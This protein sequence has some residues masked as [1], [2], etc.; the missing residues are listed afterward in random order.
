MYSE[1]IDFGIVFISE[2]IQFSIL[3]SSINPPWYSYLSRKR[4]DMS[5]VFAGTDRLCLQTMVR[6]EGKGSF[7]YDS[8]TKPPPSLLP[9][10]SDWK[11][12]QQGIVNNKIIGNKTFIIGGGGRRRVNFPI[13]ITHANFVLWQK[14]T[15]PKT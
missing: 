8:P 15:F 14:I 11:T 12:M 3:K 10:G 6:N 2:Q 7:F 5:C 1:N 9:S 4:S 13:Y